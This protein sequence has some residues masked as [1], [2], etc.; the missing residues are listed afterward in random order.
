MEFRFYRSVTKQGEGVGDEGVVGVV[1]VNK[2]P[3]LGGD[4]FSTYRRIPDGEGLYGDLLIGDRCK[5]KRTEGGDL[6]PV[7]R[8]SL[9]KENHRNSF[10]GSV[11]DALRRFYRRSK[12]PAVDKN[13]PCESGK[14]ADQRPV[15][16]IVT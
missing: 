6:A 11:N 9:W 4:L 1:P 12:R 10:R 8:L 7:V 16:Y 14:D 5:K 3:I 13:G 15:G 2:I